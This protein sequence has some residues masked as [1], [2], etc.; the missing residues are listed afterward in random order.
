MK[1]V[2]TSTALLLGVLI[3]LSKEN[4]S[5]AEKPVVI[6]KCPAYSGEQMLVSAPEYSGDSPYVHCP[7]CRAG[8]LTEDNVG[9]VR[10]SFC[11]AK[12]GE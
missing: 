4:S 9:K 11:G 6:G 3:F 7:S 12:E 2:Y 1:L 10:C 5:K 8:V